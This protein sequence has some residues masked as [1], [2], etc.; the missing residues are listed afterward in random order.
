MLEGQLRAVFRPRRKCPRLASLL[1]HG[2]AVVLSECRLVLGQATRVFLKQSSDG[3]RMLNLSLSLLY[4][5]PGGGGAGAAASAKAA[6]R[7]LDVVC[8]S[9]AEFRLWSVGLAYLAQGPPPPAALAVHRAAVQAR[10]ERRTLWAALRR[11]VD[12][13]TGGFPGMLPWEV[14]AGAACRAEAPAAARAAR[15]FEDEA[16]AAL[17]RPMST[18]PA[19]LATAC[20][21]P[22][23]AGAMLP[24]GFAEAVG[25][26]GGGSRG[27]GN[28]IRIALRKA[29]RGSND[30]FVW[31]EGAWGQLG[32][33]D[34][35]DR[36][37]A[38]L[39]P[40]LLGRAVRQV[41]AGAEHTIAITGE[42][43]ALAAVL[44]G[45][46]CRQGA[47]AVWPRS[48]SWSP[49]TS[50][51]PSQTPWRHFRGAP[52]RAAAWERAAATLHLPRSCCATRQA[53]HSGSPRS[54]AARATRLPSPLT[55]PCGHGATTL[56]VSCSSAITTAASSPLEWK[57]SPR[58][59][60]ALSMPRVGALTRL[61][62]AVSWRWSARS[63]LV[64]LALAFG[65]RAAVPW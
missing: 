17:R 5:A 1:L 32:L 37:S 23:L 25:S 43:R 42:H 14:R 44:R 64:S 45:G 20:L 16:E 19:S 31:G 13:A 35:R 9:G 65:A 24:T 21:T 22:A 61:C 58:R 7:S 6:I 18:V 54:H 12:A 53:S 29:R 41:A 34:D 2:S 36:E 33:G 4:D 30:V 62:F 11:Q 8:K 15:P 10:E 49:L 56:A 63:R 26:G 38:Q 28:E 27:R 47:R 46:M 50:L 3:I 60:F 51:L 40:L 48:D 57:R 55:G 39:L 52:A 59:G